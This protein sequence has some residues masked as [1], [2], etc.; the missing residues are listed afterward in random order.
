MG[1]IM[2]KKDALQVDVLNQ[3]YPFCH[4]DRSLPDM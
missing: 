4:A 2:S 1:I 3:V